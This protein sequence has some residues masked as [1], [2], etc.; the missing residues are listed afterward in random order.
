MDFVAGVVCEVGSLSEDFAKAPLGAPAIN[1]KGEPT[2]PNED[3]HDECEADGKGKHCT[4]SYQGEPMNL[5]IDGS[6]YPVPGCTLT[7]AFTDQGEKLS[8]RPKLTAS[9]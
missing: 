5:W 4:E 9:A 6:G 7:V 3:E 8:T 1:P 2:H